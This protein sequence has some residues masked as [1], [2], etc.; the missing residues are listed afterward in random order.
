MSWAPGVSIIAWSPAPR[1]G[2]AS[3]TFGLLRLKSCPQGQLN[4]P[5]Y[6]LSGS[7]TNNGLAAPAAAI[8]YEL[9]EESA[10]IW[11]RFMAVVVAG[12]V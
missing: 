7:A 4:Y 5:C 8:S 1:R 10:P 11:G 9:T 12:W 3:V 2:R 6:P